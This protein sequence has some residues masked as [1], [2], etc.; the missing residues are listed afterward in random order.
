MMGV[1]A[2][3]GLINVDNHKGSHHKIRPQISDPW[4]VPTKVNSYHNKAL[5]ECPKDY[6]ILAVSED[7][8]IEAIQHINLPWEGWM[9]HP[10]RERPHNSIDKIRFKR[11]LNEEKE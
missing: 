10:E 8:V 6:K 2:G 7:G 11:L 5:K 3:N 1:Y 9:W 4:S